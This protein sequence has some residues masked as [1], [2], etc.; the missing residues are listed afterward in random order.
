MVRL[1]RAAA[2][3]KIVQLGEFRPVCLTSSGADKLQN[4]PNY[5]QRA[6]AIA[7]QRYEQYSATKSI[8]LCCHRQQGMVSINN[9]I[10]PI[11]HIAADFH[12]ARTYEPTYSMASPTPSGYSG[13]GPNSLRAGGRIKRLARP[14]TRRWQQIARRRA[15]QRWAA[16]LQR[17]G[18]KC[19]GMEKHL[20]QVAWT[21]FK[22]H[23]K[24]RYQPRFVSRFVPA[25][26]DPALECVGPIDTTSG[27]PHQH[28]VALP[29]LALLSSVEAAQAS[30]SLKCLHLD[31]EIE[32]QQICDV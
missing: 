2:N 19:H 6:W 9:L 32:V 14:T 8:T 25:G 15:L 23:S 3:P 7:I 11:K 24:Q 26:P 31:H 21:A 10:N 17:V 20:G 30:E 16:L 12:E 27:C 18:G 5:L 1:W 28:V 22:R 13:R 29:K 4:S